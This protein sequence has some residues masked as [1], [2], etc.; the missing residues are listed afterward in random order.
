MKNNK[1][2]SFIELLAVMVLLGILM[3]VAIYSVSRHLD[4]ARK[5]AYLAAV[6]AQVES[7]KLLIN[8]EE[9][10]VFD[11]KTTY[12]FNYRMLKQQDDLKSPYGDWVDAYVYVIYKNEKLLYFWTGVDEAGWKIDLEKE[13]KD[14]GRQDIYHT[15]TG[16]AAL[17]IAIDGRENIVVF[18]LDEN[19]RE[20]QKTGDMA[21]NVKKAEADMCYEYEL[22][23]NN[24][25]RITGYDT[26]CGLELNIPSAIDGK[27]VTAIGA[28]AFRNKGIKKVNLYYGVKVIELGAFQKNDIV[29][30]KLP[31]TIEKIEGYAFYQ[32][33]IP[34][35]DFPEGLISIGDFG[36]ATNKIRKLVLPE[37]LVSLGSHAFYDN[38]IEDL[39]FHSNP[40]LGGAAFSKNKMPS[41]QGII[42]K[43]NSTT[44]EMDYT[45]IIGYCSDETNLVIPAT[46]GPNNVAPTTVANSAFT[47]TGITSVYMPDSITSIGS[48]SFAFNK[49]TSAHLSANLKTIGNG[50]FRNNYLTTIDIPDSVTRLGIYAFVTN[51]IKDANGNCRI[52]Y[53]RD[54][55]GVDYSTII[56]YGC[57]RNASD[58]IIP[59]TA[60]P[61]NTKLK[62]IK[63][64][65]FADSQIKSITLPELNETD[66]LTIEN[67]AFI[68]NKVPGADGFIYKV[69]NGK[70]NNAIL[71]SY[72]GPTAGSN[73]VI[74][75]PETS[76]DS[77]KKTVKLT[78]IQASFGWMSY[79]KVIVPKT[80]TSI[81]NS[82]F[83]HSN[84][85]NVNLT[86]IVN[87]TGRSFDWY[88]ITSS[89]V[90][91]PGPFITGKVSHQSGDIMI[92]GE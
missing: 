59:A 19:G 64:S 92:V 36:F 65:A 87:L 42:Y 41:G 60:G 67:N 21:Y 28:G 13:T 84:R 54:A 7:V 25:Y 20:T 61:N 37:S 18:D 79:K 14:M 75:I 73:G 32:N 8:S 12:I 26:S 6:N 86:T 62:L 3:G 57:G 83:A 70:M 2:F 63:E 88:T 82:V 46:A 90:S 66:S 51:N 44:K 77:S 71:S 56:S 40:T 15:S 58:L 48:D 53:A 23:E 80:V 45:T 29:E 31:S 76:V 89:T 1:G 24:T 68:R 85:N 35:V 16:G 91:N 9:Y 11:E 52:I 27:T 10:Y 47:S 74:T 38:L 50:A 55:N 17:G 69:T 4:N 33:K 49:I 72:A 22:L 34:A 43:Y 30:L 81:S 78:T 5:D 39:E